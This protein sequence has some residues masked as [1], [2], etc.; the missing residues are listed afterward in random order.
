[1]MDVSYHCINMNYKIFDVKDSGI[2]YVSFKNLFNVV[3][4]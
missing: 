1:M 3:M 2:E 4:R